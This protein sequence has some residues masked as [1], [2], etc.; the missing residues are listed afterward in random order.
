MIRLP[1]ALTLITLCLFFYSCSQDYLPK[2][3]GY[4]RIELPDPKYISL[5]DSLPY[6]FEY[7]VHANIYKD[8]SW[9][10]ERYWINIYYPQLEASV[11][12]TYKPVLSRQDLLEEYLRDAHTLTSKHQ[13]KAYAID[14]SIIQ[15][16]L[17][18]TVVISELSGE[19]PSQFQFY[20]TDSTKHFLRG[21][22]YF[23]TATKND[24]L[25]PVIQY[26][27]RDILQMVNTLEWKDGFPVQLVI[28]E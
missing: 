10:A 8:S 4:N 15:T 21:A 12:I 17:G 1:G 14:E 13:I 2:P 9:M 16:P 5:P 26:V 18:N 20:V 7:S 19:V 28:K 23:R 22:L 6:D 24:S 27:K 11:Q 3:K 25:A